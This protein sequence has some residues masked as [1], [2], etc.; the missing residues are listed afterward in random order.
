MDPALLMSVLGQ[1]TNLAPS[2]FQTG[3]GIAQLI[4]A[5]KI[6]DRFKQPQF[7]I[8]SAYIA[9][10]DI[11]K[12]LASQRELPGTRRFT[13]GLEK[14]QADTLA[15]LKERASTPEELLSGLRTVTDVT[16]EKKK[17]W[18]VAGE[19]YYRKNQEFLSKYLEGLS[20]LQ[21]RQWMFN[22]YMPYLEAMETAKGLSGSGLSNLYSGFSN[23]T[24][25]TQ[26]VLNTLA[27]NKDF[28]SMFSTGM[29][30][31]YGRL[32][33]VPEKLNAKMPVLNINRPGI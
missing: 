9:A 11:A 6:A 12:D 7:Q 17:D 21:E 13:E 27:S 26:N 3:T 18:G 14:T 2:L 20:N 28:L 1:A 8:P 15:A 24:G 10:G 5:K 31:N 29:K 32:M 23:I 22:K 4:G 30:E 25:V 16:S 19:E 33:D